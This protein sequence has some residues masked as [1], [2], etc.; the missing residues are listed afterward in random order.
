MSDKRNPTKI[1]IQ[2]RYGH[3]EI[4]VAQLSNQKFTHTLIS[5]Q[6]LLQVLVQ[7]LSS[8]QHRPV[9]LQTNDTGWHSLVF[10]N[11]F[12]RNKYLCWLALVES[13]SYDRRVKTLWCRI[14]TG[15]GE[16]RN[17]TS[18][19]TLVSRGTITIHLILCSIY[20]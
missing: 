17:V 12:V 3:I 20:E 13:H 10:Q 7:L 4:P 16:S 8:P 11:K 18:V 2:T 6:K 15:G 5:V 14:H 19:G 9:V 1:Q